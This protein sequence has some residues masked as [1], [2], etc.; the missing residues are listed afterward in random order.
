MTITLVLSGEIEAELVASLAD[1]LETAGVLLARRVETPWGTKLLAHEKLASAT[2][3]YP[4]CPY[5]T[6]YSIRQ[7]SCSR[8]SVPDGLGLG[9]RNRVRVDV[10]LFH[11]IV[12]G[13]VRCSVTGS[14]PVRLKVAGAVVK[15]DGRYLA[16]LT[17]AAMAALR[18]TPSLSRMLCT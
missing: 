3:S 15:A 5:S 14:S 8:S 18:R 6:H 17:L 1:P 16:S 7:R 12:V 4:D 10:H 13:L 2:C 11:K 9:G